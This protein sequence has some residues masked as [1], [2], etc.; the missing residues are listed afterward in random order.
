MWYIYPVTQSPLRLKFVPEFQRKII[1]IQ[2]VCNCIGGNASLYTGDKN[3]YTT[4]I[5]LKY[6]QLTVQILSS[7]SLIIFLMCLHHLTEISLD[8]CTPSTSL[9]YL[10]LIRP[11][12]L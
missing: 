12:H 3:I 6:I 4:K 5:I 1:K 9:V 2:I 7:F 8:G 10:Y 11:S